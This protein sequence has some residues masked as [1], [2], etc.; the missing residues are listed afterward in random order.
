L[1]VCPEER[2]PNVVLLRCSDGGIGS[3]LQIIC[4]DDQIHRYDTNR[5]EK[6]KHYEIEHIKYERTYNNK[7]PWPR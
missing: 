4:W 2:K 6:V 3:G 7:E 5:G 1:T